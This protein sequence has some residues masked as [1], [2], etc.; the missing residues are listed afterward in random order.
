MAAGET[1]RYDRPVSRPL[2]PSAGLALLAALLGV[3][4]ACTD[5]GSIGAGSGRLCGGPVVGTSDAAFIRRGFCESVTLELAFRPLVPEHCRGLPLGD[6]TFEALLTTSDGAFECA[7]VRIVGPVE[8]DL[9]GR[10]DFPGETRL[11]N[12]IYSVRRTRGP[13]DGSV[14]LCSELAPEQF[15]AEAACGQDATLFVS[16]LDGGGVEARLLGGAGSSSTGERCGAA[17]ADYSTGRDLF[18]LFRLSCTQ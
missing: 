18:G 4:S 3:V 16:F 11:E 15:D 14:R 2:A 17:T 12:K 1:R 5:I 10:Y 9:L 6:T 7:P 8:Q 13:G